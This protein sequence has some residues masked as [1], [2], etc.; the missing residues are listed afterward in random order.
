VNA[1]L[2]GYRGASERFQMSHALRQELG[3]ALNKAAGDPV[4]RLSALIDVGDEQLCPSNVL[5]YVS[6]LVV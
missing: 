4:N 2:A 5:L 3:L 1:Q 6:L